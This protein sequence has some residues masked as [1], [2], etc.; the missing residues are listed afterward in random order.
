MP[1]L[2]IIMFFILCSHSRV[3]AQDYRKIFREDYNQGLSI[4]EKNDALFEKAA[5]KYQVNASHL[6]AIVFP[7][8]IR[9]NTVFDFMEITSLKVL[10][11]TNGKDYANFSVGYFQMKPSFAEQ[12]E[13]D[14]SKYLDA[15]FLSGFEMPIQIN[16]ADPTKEREER[17]RRL[18]TVEGQLQYLVLFYK[19]C[20]KKF[21]LFTLNDQEKISFLST[22]YNAGYHR[23]YNA[24]AALSRKDLF[25]TGTVV[26]GKRFNYAS[27]SLFWYR[28]QAQ[29][30]N[31]N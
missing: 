3:N 13:S 18:T 14:A 16:I 24:V 11:I 23:S 22:C 5:A 27:I 21:N 20:E 2:Y 26:S 19:I 10:Y 8:L 31:V 30:A 28:Q 9:Y 29:L 17:V 12:L 1:R 15:R 25:Y 4:L 6:K 7:E